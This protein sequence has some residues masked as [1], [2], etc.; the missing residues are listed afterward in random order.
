ML[1][2]QYK[3]GSRRDKQ[4]TLSVDFKIPKTLIPSDEDLNRK[5]FRDDWGLRQSAND[6]FFDNSYWK[7]PDGYNIDELL[8]EEKVVDK[9]E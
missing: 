8:E 1:I 3:G 7:V 9:K 4:R 5:N 2:K 6:R